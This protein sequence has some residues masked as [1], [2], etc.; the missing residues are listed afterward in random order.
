[1]GRE[2]WGEG[3]TWNRDAS[4]KVESNDAARRPVSFADAE[5]GTP[6]C[7]SGLSPQWGFFLFTTSESRHSPM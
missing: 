7:L 4:E 5:V 2:G 3:R 6:R 1:M